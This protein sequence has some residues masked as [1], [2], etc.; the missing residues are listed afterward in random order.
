MR[1]VG[2][3]YSV[4][5]KGMGGAIVGIQVDIAPGLPRVHVVGLPD[6][7]IAQAKH[8]TWS[9][10]THSGFQP[11]DTK[12]VVNLNPGDVPKEGSHFDLPIAIALL[13]AQGA[14]PDEARPTNVIGELGLDG[15]LHPCRSILPLVRAGRDSGRTR[16]VVPSANEVEASLVHGVEVIAVPSLAHAAAALGADIDPVPVE[17][18]ALGTAPGRRVP[19]PDMADVIGNTSAIHAVEV[20]AAGGHHISLLGPPGAGKTMLAS[21]LPGL[22][23]EL[24]PEQAL[25]VAVLRGI[26]GEPSME[27]LDTTPPFEAPHHT[28]SAVSLVGGGPTAKPG[29]ISRANHGVLFLDEAAEFNS[30]VLNALRQSLESGSIRVDRQKVKET[31][32]ARFQLVMASNPC[33]C[34]M[35]GFGSCSCSAQQRLRYAAKLSGPILDRIDLQVSVDRVTSAVRSVSEPAPSTAEIKARVAEARRRAGRRLADT[36]WSCMGQV[37][38]TW[39]RKHHRLPEDVTGTMDDALRRGMISMRGYDRILRVAYT[40]G[41]LAG[42]DEPGRAEIGKALSFR[43]IE[44]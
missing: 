1:L 19:V 22:L 17:A 25:D 11:P 23:P 33:P 10:L 27:Y 43:R 28:A 44:K 20:A 40:M 6:A 14:V 35:Y 16:V 21:R 41:D 18:I 7:A 36:P 15:R 42:M 24:T 30:D 32:P 5:P 12:V 13:R 3:T 37:P 31:Y 39:L 38:G 2:N 29:A 4:T 9:A 34:G 8:R 26:C